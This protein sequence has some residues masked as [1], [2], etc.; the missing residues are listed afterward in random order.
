MPL[1]SVIVPVYKV[2]AYLDR[3]VQSIVNQTY[4]N[5]EI[6]LVD[7]GSPDHCPAMCDTWASKDD[8]IKVIHKRNGGLSDARNVGLEAASGGLIGF[9]D[10]DDY[11]SPDMYQLLY[12]NMS[13]NRTD[14]SCCG[15]LMIWENNGNERR[16]TKD[17]SVVL[18]PS[19]AMLAIVNETWLKHPVWNR[20]YKKSCI[21][22]IRFPVGKVHEDA[23][24]SYRV[25]ANAKKVSIFEKPCYF[26][27]QRNESI[28]GQAYSEKRLDLLDAYLDEMNFVEENYPEIL[29][30]AVYLFCF[31]LLYAYQSVLRIPNENERT[32]CLLRLQKYIV[33]WKENRNIG[34]PEGI[35][36]RIW[37][38]LATISVKQTAKLRN[39]LKVGM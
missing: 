20:L 29:G 11:I 2:E 36:Q 15:I 7:D 17:E 1:I 16:L 34:Q 10:S 24:W 8:R 22:D 19:E 9:V 27:W 12:S 23:F 3:C 31:R 18:N 28:M 38:F 6:I 5:L 26:Y 39:I 37:Y 32:R 35:K 13:T 14:I 21:N 25:I 4:Q 30:K 33:I